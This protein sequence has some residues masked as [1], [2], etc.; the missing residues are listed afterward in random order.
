M[1]DSLIIQNEPMTVADRSLTPDEFKA[2]GK[3]LFGN[4][5]FWP[6]AAARELRVNRR[7]VARWA[8]GSPTNLPP[9]WITPRLCEILERRRPWVHDDE[10]EAAAILGLA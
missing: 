10:A 4:S 6:E 7:T 3:A 5:K 1:S 8:S 9:D 2:V